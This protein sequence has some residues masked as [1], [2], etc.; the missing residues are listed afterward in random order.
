MCRP[1]RLRFTLALL[2]WLAPAAAH[3]QLAN[4]SRL[5]LDTAVA[6]DETVEGDGNRTTGFSADALASF[7]LGGGVQLM[8]RPFVQRLRSGDWNVQVWVA[9]L[10]YERP[11]NIGVRV[12]AGLIP[13]PIGMANLTLRPHLN[14]TI[15]QPSSL[16][17]PLPRSALPVRAALLG[18]VYPMGAS[19]TVS[20][21]GWDLRA[22]AIDTSPVRTRRI[23]A[24]DSPA[25][26]PRFA[27]VVIGGGITPFVG[28]RVGAS[29]ARGGWLKAG[30]SPIVTTDRQATVFT[31]E[32]EF[33]YRYTRV[34]GEWV[35]DS[36]DTIAG[37]RVAHG[38]FVQ[39]QQTL[40]P[41]WF[42]AGRAERMSAPAVSPIDAIVRQR[43]TGIEETLGFRIAPEVTLRV[44]H[45]ARE[46]FGVNGFAH[47]ATVSV[48]FWKR[49]M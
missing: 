20:S 4:P 32:S 11:G 24:D 13:S 22:A 49:W 31:V 1:D 15:A 18:P 39:A 5:A 36:L 7:E 3:A 44:S 14:P 30:E 37:P 9:G 2:L 33:S 27:N 46:G 29:L 35:R 48:V 28:F 21:L 45:R 12:D 40:T 6:I 42:V 17:T 23:F 10:R 47:T 34:L 16:F 8:T 25:N 38:F 26:P 41:R 19:V 43:F